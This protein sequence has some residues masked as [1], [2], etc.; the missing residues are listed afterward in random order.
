MLSVRIRALVTW[1][2][3][4]AVALHVILLGFLPVNPAFSGPIDPFAIICHTT[5]TS[6]KPGAP[7]PGT[8]KYLPGRAN[9]FCSLCSA[10]APPPAPDAAF[11]IDYWPTRI[12]HVLRPVSAS[13]TSRLASNLK[14]ARGPPATA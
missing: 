11:H 9:D 7:P 6:A 12:L 3:I 1:V 13:D 5:G 14:L 4:Y 2:A 8:L 10:A